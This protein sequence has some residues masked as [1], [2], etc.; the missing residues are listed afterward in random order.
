M[1]TPI[2]LQSMHVKQYMSIEQHKVSDLFWLLSYKQTK[3]KCI[4]NMW[5]V[6]NACKLCDRNKIPYYF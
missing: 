1:Y 4:Y 3:H 6:R 2:R 5:K